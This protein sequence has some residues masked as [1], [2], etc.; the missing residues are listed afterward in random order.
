MKLLNG[1]GM[2][3]LISSLVLFTDSCKKNDTPNGPNDLGGETNIP[4]TQ[5]GSVTSAYIKING[6][7]MPNGEMSVTSNNNGIVQYHFDIES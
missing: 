7:N 4:L 3:A 5:V 1:I 6:V 2:A